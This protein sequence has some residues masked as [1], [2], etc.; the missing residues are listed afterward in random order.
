MNEYQRAVDILKSYV[1]S[2]GIELFSSDVIKTDLDEFKR[3]FSPEKLQALDD[4]QLLSTIFFSLGDN[5]NTLCYWLEMKGNIKEH[6]GSVAG[7]SSYKFGLFQNQKSG[8]WMTGSSTKP[9]SLKVDEALALGK[10]IRDALVIGANIIHDTKLETV[11]DYEQ[12]NDT[13]KDKVGE[14]YYKLGWV[15]KYFSMICSDKLSG[16][17]SEEWQKHVLRALRIKPSEKTYG[18]SG[19]ISIIQN[20]AGLYYKQFLDIFKSRFGEVRQFIRLG[21]S[22]SKKNYANEW[23]KQGIIGFGYSKIGDLSKGVFIDHLDKSTILHE[24]VKNYEISDKRYASRIA[25]EILRFY[26]SDSNTIFTIMTGEKLI[27]YADQIGA[28]SYSSDS[29]MSH[30]KTANWKLVFEE[31]EKLPEK[32]EGLRTICYPFSNDE[33]LLFLYDRY[34]Y[35]NEKSDFIKDKDKSNIDHEKGITFYTKIESPF[36]RNR[37]MFGAPGTGKSFNLNEDA[38]KLLGDAYEINLERVTFHPDYSYAN[39]V[40]TYKPVPVKDYGKDSIT[41]AYVPGPFMRV[42]VEAL[43]NSR[44]DTIKPFL[45]L[46]EEINRANVA[47]VFGDI[48]QLLDRGFNNVSEYPIHASEDIKNYLANELGGNSSDYSR[49]KIP[50]NM[51]IWASMNSADQGVFPMDTAFKRRWS[52]QYLGIDDG[53]KEIRA[54]YVYLGGKEKQKIEWNS[55]R[56]A[57]N[58]FLA[59]ENI[60]EDKQL[61]PYFISKKILMADNDKIDSD[62]FCEVFKHKVLMYLFEDVARQKRSKLFANSKYGYTR[63]SKICKAFDEQGVEIFHK[64]IQDEIKRIE[65]LSSETDNNDLVHLDN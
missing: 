18:R 36:E 63:Y 38:K 24:L 27:A 15:H 26:N 39:F 47:A 52:F 31:G 57:I 6:F 14:K 56:K 32:S 4:T 19:Q 43:K 12:L 45:L 13:L 11:E 5:T 2:E 58:E 55:L 42:Y 50:D 46:I 40:G 44:T 23:C 9:E 25:G 54:K 8:V 62:R 7:G 22:D 29:D 28:Y 37:I 49:L 41:Y 61:G 53:D 48:F 60:N 20:L 16:F 59:N 21:C 3:V 30:K 35:G 1:D 51:F 65:S 17:H 33:N 34:Y 64:D 10:R